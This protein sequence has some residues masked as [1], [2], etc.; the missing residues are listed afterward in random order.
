[1]IDYIAVL[2]LWSM[3]GPFIFIKIIDLNNG[4]INKYKINLLVLMGGPLIW[5]I[6]LY[7]FVGCA[8]KVLYKLIYST[9]TKIGFWFGE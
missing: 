6:K 4:Q 8:F 1:M 9:C 2:L 3:F 5:I 7:K